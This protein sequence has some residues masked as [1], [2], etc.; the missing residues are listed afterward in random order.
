MNIYVSSLSF[1]VNS[2]DLKAVFEEFGVVESANIINDKIT[3]RSRGFGFVEMPNKEE[4]EKAIQGLNGR[5]MDGR[6][7][8]V[9]EAKERAPREGGFNRSQSPFKR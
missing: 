1:G 5:S 2:D 7:I 8:N 4:A 3:Q 9:V 6:T